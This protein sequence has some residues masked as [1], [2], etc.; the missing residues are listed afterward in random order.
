VAHFYIIKYKRIK[1]EGI[2]FRK[3]TKTDGS[4]RSIAVTD[5][6]IHF[7]KK[8]KTKQAKEKLALGSVY[9][10]HDLVF[11]NSEGDALD[12]DGLS[13]EFSRLV[14]R[15]HLPHVRFHDLRHTHAT[16][17]LQQGIHP[18][19]VSERL[20]HSTIAMTMDTYSHVMPNMQKEAAQKLDDFLFGG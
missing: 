2:Q 4:R 14:K 3:T 16:L 19:V 18:K 15:L 17:L 5:S 10:D 11:A 6:T 20:G 1:G 9:K 8:L 13:R 7:L 12:P